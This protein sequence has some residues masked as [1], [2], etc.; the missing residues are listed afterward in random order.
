[1]SVPD[2]AFLPNNFV[3]KLIKKKS[4]RKISPER[5]YRPKTNIK[6]NKNTKIFCRFGPTP[7]L[8]SNRIYP[9]DKNSIN[10]IKKPSLVIKFIFSTRCNKTFK[11]IPAR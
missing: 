5:K 10:I 8:V 11:N 7:N 3:T 6:K 4:I 1:M 2:T 9:M